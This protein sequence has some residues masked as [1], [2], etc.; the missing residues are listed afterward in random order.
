[1]AIAP[2]TA[3]D[4]RSD[5]EDVLHLYCTLLD[6]RRPDLLVTEVYAPDAVDDRRR[7]TLRQGTEELQDYFTAAL[8]VLEA[9]VHLLSNVV[10]RLDGEDARA[11]SRVQACHWFAATARLGPVRAC[12]CVLVATYDD[13]FHRF[14]YGW[15]ITRRQV[16]VGGPGGLLTGTM[17]AAW[18][19]FGGI[20][21]G[22]PGQA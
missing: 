7:G 5:I 11:S 4:D 3:V 10:I 20:H 8:G 12:E 2:T 17:P 18:A 19:G 13:E 16:T 9:T 15:R 14:S 1:M 21:G 22:G 6:N